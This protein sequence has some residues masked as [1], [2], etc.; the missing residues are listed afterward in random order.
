M[1][2]LTSLTAVL[3]TCLATAALLLACFGAGRPLL[4]LLDHEADDTLDTVTW[5]MALGLAAAGC[6][7]M[8]LGLCGLLYRPVIGVLTMTVCFWGLGEISL[9]YWERKD[10]QRAR[11]WPTAETQSTAGRLPRGLGFA[12]VALCASVAAG[13]FVSALAPPTAGDALYY[14]LDLPKV[15]LQEHALVYLPDHEKSTFPLLVEMWFLW[16]LALDG[17][18]AAQLIHWFTGLL[19]AAATVLLARPLVGHTW[20]YLAGAVVLLVPGV[21]LQMT[22]PLNDVGAALPTTLAL[23]AWHKAA[24]QRQSHRWY[25]L[26]GAMLG[27]GLGAKYTG[28]LFLTAFAAVVAL[29]IWQRQAERR[30]LL[31]GTFLAACALMLVAA[32]WYARAAWHRGNPVY[33]FFHQVVS[34]EGTDVLPD[35]KTPLGWDAVAVA[36]SPA[37]ITLFPERFGGRGHQ[38]GALFLCAL[39]G[40]LIARPL[41]GLG[42]LLKLAAVYSVLWYALRQNVRF[43][44]P[45][46]PLLAIGVVWT[47]VELRQWP[48]HPRTLAYV[49]VASLFVVGAVVP[50]RRAAGSAAV[51]TGWESREAFLTHHE[52]TYRAAELANL[53]VGP[54]SHILS[55]DYRGYYFKS[56]VT[57][58]KQYRRRNDYTVD[59]EH[60]GGLSAT[61]RG[62]GFT[63]LLLAETSGD[64]GIQFDPTLSNLVDRELA[65]ESEPGAEQTLLVL[66]DYQVDDSDGIRRRYRLIMLR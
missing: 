25:V 53:L 60:S 57:W 48:R 34:S 47:I 66:H 51:A 22:A 43:L 7:L 18:V 23:V 2:Y 8:F 38:L 54:D 64:Q 1:E 52:P 4:R 13:S 30:V 5:S 15:F 56:R 14:H 29:R 11:H 3:T 16:A 9:L 41:R 31:R 19:W 17:P 55:Q 46:V 35:K 45:I 42:E 39:P 33:P 20:A 62:A 61:L 6:V 27:A 58:D 12:C 65:A 28:L 40:L 37:H 36:M 10:R 49:A 32:P 63:H 21:S 50:W 59:V 24:C 26:A 44:L